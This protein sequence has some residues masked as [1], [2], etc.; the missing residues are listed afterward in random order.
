M[1]FQHDGA[2]AEISR[3]IP[4]YFTKCPRG[5]HDRWMGRGRIEQ[6]SPIPNY[7]CYTYTYLLE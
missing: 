2:Q 5:R 3:N 7:I 1:E 4:L 6:Q